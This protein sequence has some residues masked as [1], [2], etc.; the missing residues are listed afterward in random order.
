MNGVLAGQR[1]SPLR[2]DDGLGR[3]L[4][5][6]IV[7][8]AVVS[9][10][11]LS[12]FASFW[13]TGESS[14]TLRHLAATVIPSALLQTSVLGMAVMTGVVAIGASTAWVVAT[15]D[16][17][18]RR[19]FEWALLLP[20]AMPAYIVAYAYTDYL[21]YAGPVQTALRES[22]GWQKNDYW[23]PEIRS[24][25]GATFVF[26]VVLYPYVYLLAR[27]A[28]LARTAAMMD[29]ARSLGNTAWQTW[30]TVNLPLA[31][32][33]IAAGALLALMETIA[34]YGAA[35][36]FGLQ[37]FTTSIY[38]AWFALGDR[39][40]ASQLSAVLLLLVLGVFY[41]E[42]R[43]RGRAR[44]FTPA[45]SQR[46]AARLLLAGRH[47]I[48]ALTLCAAP[49]V[50]GFVVP[51]VLLLRL[52]LPAWDTI[53]GSRYVHWLSNTLMIGTAA[54]VLAL[55]AVLALAYAARSMTRGAPAALI[56]SA[57]GLMS[58]GYAVPGAVIAVGILIPLAAFDNRLDAV[59][60]SIV[61]VGTGLLLTG[62]VF[63]LLYGYLVRYFAVGY[64][65]VE[66]GL[67]RIT[68]SMD[69]TARSLGSTPFD[70]FVRVHLPILRPSVLAAG[71]LVFVDVMK[72]LPATLVLRPFN[73]DTL[74]VV[75]YQM[76][77]DERL[78]QAALPA[79][80]I[81]AAGIVPVALLS[82]AISSASRFD[83]RG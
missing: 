11:V 55:V 42:H 59:T 76:A 71:L 60:Q 48:A 39:L 80:T 16:F 53:D 49:I 44:F 54:A 46:P 8:G 4:S 75:T 69:A 2:G 47:R 56:R 13:H 33:A 22:F 63:A 68:P 81:V 30:W 20:L 40:A 15:C 62:S 72:E 36:Y 29:A 17:P 27:T 26:T 5:L 25:T 1:F 19:I 73:F 37:T 79:L 66:A 28:F 21:Q 61:G 32:P 38:R 52:L 74:A 41:I 34:D 78:G 31:R 24:L 58:L 23:F 3:A 35:S 65:A 10:P 82:R 18:G 83:R 64:Q 45:N 12:V 51:V 9:L 14:D 6:L 43:A 67:T 70:T 57:V 7:C 77:S 50:L